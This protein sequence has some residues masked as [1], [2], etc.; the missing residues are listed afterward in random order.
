MPYFFDTLPRG[1]ATV[2][3]DEHDHSCTV[4]RNF[5]KMRLLFPL[6]AISGP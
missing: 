2:R 1:F 4:V 3:V 5:A 6:K